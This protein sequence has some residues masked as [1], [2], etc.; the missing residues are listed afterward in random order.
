VLLDLENV[1]LIF[2]ETLPAGVMHYHQDGG[3]GRPSA[4]L[5]I[6]S[7]GTMLT[8]SKSGVILIC[9]AVSIA[10]RKSYINSSM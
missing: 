10:I 1:E 9:S 7:A 6:R 2:P 5:E 4:L 3:I 8:C